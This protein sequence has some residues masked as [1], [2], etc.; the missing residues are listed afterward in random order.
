MRKSA[1]N[2]RSRKSGDF[3]SAP[4]YPVNWR[5]MLL[6]CQVRFCRLF[7]IIPSQSAHK[8]RD[9]HVIRSDVS[10]V[11]LLS[12]L[13]ASQIWNDEDRIKS[14]EATDLWY[15][16]NDRSA[17]MSLMQS[18]IQIRED[19][20]HVTRIVTGRGSKCWDV[21]S[22]LAVVVIPLITVAYHHRDRSITHK[23]APYE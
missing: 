12:G 11:F 19:I 22:D 1:S 15:S 10:R 9:A 6:G 23:V 14:T 13:P 16:G 20:N 21:T 18:C 2:P 7:I 4:Q 5:G 3:R 17:R 8:G